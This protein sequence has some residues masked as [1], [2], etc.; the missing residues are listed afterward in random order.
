MQ[1]A[2][3]SQVTHLRAGHCM[4]VEVNAQ[5]VLARPVERLECVV[6]RGVR[7]EGLVA[8]RAECIERD[9]ESDPVQTGASNL[10]EVLLG[11]RTASVLRQSNHVEQCA[12]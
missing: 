1:A 12:R 3:Y 10:R 6:P 7:E 11:L 9:G 8:D 2:E 5:A 4:Q